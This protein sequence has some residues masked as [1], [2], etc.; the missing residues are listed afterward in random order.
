MSI[1]SELSEIFGDAFASLDLE[2]AYGEVVVSARPDLADFQCNGALPAAKPAGKNPQQ[3]AK[4]VIAAL[5]DTSRFES[6]TVAGPGFINIVLTNQAVADAVNA[7]A[8]HDRLGLDPVEP[9]KVVVDYGGPNVAKEL[10]VGHL[11]PAIIGESVKRILR[12][13][14]HDVIGDVH[15]GDWGAPQ[16]QLIAELQDRNPEWVYFDPLSTGP[17]PEEPP[18]TMDELQEIYPIAAQRARDDLVF[19][20][21]A[22]R[23]VVELQ[24]GRPG[25]L[26]LWKH[27]R[28]VSV[29]AI[30][31]VYDR[32][33]V[34]F[35]LWYGESSIKDRLEPLIE[36]LR[37]SGVARESDGALVIDV[38]EPGDTKEIPP[39][40]LVK[41]DGATLYTTWDVATIEDRVDDLGA[42]VMVYVVDTRQ[43]LHF[44]QVFRAARKAGIAGP[45]VVL[46]HEGNGTVNGPDGK[47]LKTREGDLPLL[48]D[49]MD[50]VVRT[51]AARLD[52][53]HLATG[54]PEEERAD[55]ACKV[56]LA[57]LKYGDLR[58]HRASDY[59]FD[60][61]RFVSFEGK[62]GPYLL[63]SAVR[64]R[65]ILRE[66][67]ARGIEPGEVLVAA[68][69]Q[70]RNL[71]LQVLRFPGAVHRAA[72]H[73]APNHLAEYAYELAAD[74]SRFYEACHI[75]SE[76]DAGQ[77]A[78]WLG[79]V[80][81]TLDVL[82][83]ALDLLG[84]DVP[85][86]M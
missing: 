71:M 28:D 54:Y 51:A 35:D 65:S 36:R 3:L 74:F 50:D 16:G 61:D 62:T 14:G 82:T 46:R 73:H 80:V 60:L 58:N 33:G 22:R 25:Y 39:L 6:V 57:A 78:G 13:M 10:H 7:A 66:A 72:E 42:E 48:R 26:A 31:A 24:D 77:Q 11:R 12:F 19:G 37:E 55:I 64:M 15:L 70:D 52:E 85:E 20:E 4:E 27:M 41:S 79:L 86:R 18:V 69:E 2:R 68:N 83:T 43:S 34:Q 75:L 40:M 9:R 84:I 76:E 21:A 53:N 1:T 47:P 45:D 44:E 63:Y 56:G 8:G 30:R 29:D 32:L 38:A 17:Y 5:H 59:I 67:A 23:A 49:L 81:T